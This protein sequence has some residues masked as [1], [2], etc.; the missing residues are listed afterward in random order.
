[1]T[2]LAASRRSQESLQQQHVGIKHNGGAQVSETFIA[3]LALPC[4]WGDSQVPTPAGAGSTHESLV[5]FS[6][7][8][9]CQEL[10]NRTLQRSEE[11]QDTTLDQS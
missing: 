8:T 5:A 10:K 7:S 6:T 1:M 9:L 4:K 3:P 11:L 2:L